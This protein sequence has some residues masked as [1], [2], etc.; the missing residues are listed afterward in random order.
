MSHIDDAT[1]ARAQ[2]WALAIGTIVL[3]NA[4]DDPLLAATARTA[5]DRVLADDVPGS[6]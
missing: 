4:D 6:G 1:W 5:V 2:G 3:V